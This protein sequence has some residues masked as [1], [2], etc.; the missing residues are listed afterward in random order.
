MTIFADF[1]SRYSRFLPILV[2]A[3]D[4]RTSFFPIIVTVVLFP[5][6]RRCLLSR[7][8]PSGIGDKNR[9]TPLAAE[10]GARDEVVGGIVFILYAGR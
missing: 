5:N 2:V 3:Q 8:H 7:Q 9:A 4:D 6:R 1:L 10:G